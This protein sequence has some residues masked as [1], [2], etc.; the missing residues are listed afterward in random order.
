MGKP[1]KFKDSDLVMVFGT[2]S[3][4]TGPGIILGYVADRK[5]YR[6]RLQQTGARV[7]VPDQCIKILLEK[8]SSAISNQRSANKDRRSAISE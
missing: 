4:Q 5:L 3:I 8:K 7:L 6:V 1:R 2:V